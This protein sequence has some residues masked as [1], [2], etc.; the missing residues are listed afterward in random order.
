[1]KVARPLETRGSNKNSPPGKKQQWLNR[2]KPEKEFKAEKG[3][4]SYPK[5]T[6]SRVE[7]RKKEIGRGSI[8]GITAK[9]KKKK[10]LDLTRLDDLKT[11]PAREDH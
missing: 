10:I 4:M 6:P 1:V 7:S 2:R 5:K 8:W 11:D 9:N 3:G